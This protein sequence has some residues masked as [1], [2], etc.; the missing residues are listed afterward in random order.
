MLSFIELL[1]YF[2]RLE[3]YTALERPP[4]NLLL[5]NESL[6]LFAMLSPPNE[7]IEEFVKLKS[8]LLNEYTSMDAKPANGSSPS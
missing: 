1:K 6:S 2:F 5:L 3:P 8:V 4:L 7:P